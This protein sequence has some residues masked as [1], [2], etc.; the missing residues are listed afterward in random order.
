MTNDALTRCAAYQEF[1]IYLAEKQEDAVSRYD[2]PAIG[3]V[4]EAIKKQH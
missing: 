2:C 3:H 1:S 4:F